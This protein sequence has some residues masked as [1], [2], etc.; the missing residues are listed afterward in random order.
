MEFSRPTHP[1]VTHTV[2]LLVFTPKE[3][4]SIPFAIV[5]A[6]TIKNAGKKEDQLSILNVQRGM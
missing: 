2:G 3:S 1:R 5:Q 4:R 6:E